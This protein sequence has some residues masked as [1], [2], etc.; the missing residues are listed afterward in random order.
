[1]VDIKDLGIVTL[2]IFSI[3]PFMILVTLYMGKRSV[4][5]LPVFD[6]L[7]VLVF[8][9]V[10]G[11]DIADPDINHV[12][13][14]VAMLLIGILQKILT[15]MKISSRKIGKLL[16]FE[17]T[18][19]IENG[20]ILKDELKG[21]GYTIDNILMLLR[22]K[23]VFQLQDVQ[24]GIIEPNGNLSIHKLPSK[25]ALTAEDTGVLKGTSLAFPLIVD[26]VMHESVLDTLNVEEKWVKDELSRAGFN[27][28][29]DVFY[30][31]INARKEIHIVKTSDTHTYPHFYN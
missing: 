10:V 9:S 18:V 6:F 16:S 5:E 12:H 20:Q 1:M 11:A 4:G 26:G 13:T 29:E 19:V 15:K 23:E 7:V 21:T 3:L 17:P 31:S 27:S 24:I 22:E 2:R 8:G 30:A 28:F 14:I 25:Q